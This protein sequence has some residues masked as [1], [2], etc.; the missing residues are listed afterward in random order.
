MVGPG[1]GQVVEDRDQCRNVARDPASRSP[2]TQHNSQVIK[3]VFLAKAKN[4]NVECKYEW[5]FI[6]I[7]PLSSFI[8]DNCLA[9]EHE[10]NGALLMKFPDTKID[11]LLIFYA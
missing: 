9:Y 2:F 11:Y 1:A 7:V 8:D 6:K 10:V 5:L 4:S 3:F